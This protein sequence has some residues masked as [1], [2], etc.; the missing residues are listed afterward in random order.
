MLVNLVLLTALAQPAAEP[1]APGA[2]PPEQAM[3][4]IDAQ[5]NLKITIVSCACYGPAEQEV[6]AAVPDKP[7]PDKAAAKVKVKVTSVLV[8]TAELSAKAVEAYTADGASLGKEKLAE[9]LARERTVLVATDGK[10]VDP[11]FLELYKEGTVVLV[12]PANVLGGGANPY[13][14]PMVVP[15]PEPRRIPDAPDKP[16]EKPLDTKPSPR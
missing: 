5:G 13:S 16:A 6:E 14:G 1:A 11:F 9:L 10:K 4:V 2:L 15:A 12:P 7:G 3:A 8:T